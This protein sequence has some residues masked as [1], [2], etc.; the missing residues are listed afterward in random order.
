MIGQGLI[1]EA[2]EEPTAVTMAMA[3][4]ITL[5]TGIGRRRRLAHMPGMGMARM[6]TC[7]ITI[8]THRIRTG[9]TATVLGA[10]R[11]ATTHGPRMGGK[12][13]QTS[14]LSPA[15]IL[16]DR[17]FFLYRERVRQHHAY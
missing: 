16:A 17:A 6:I 8:P 3:G 14:V 2:G 10:T 9:V 13:V 7:H 12:R 15:V 1:A 5:R 11:K 4:M